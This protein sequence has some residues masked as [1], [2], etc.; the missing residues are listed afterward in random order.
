MTSVMEIQAE[1][2]KNLPQVCE[3][4]PTVETVTPKRKP[5]YLFLKRSFDILAALA[6]GVIWLLPMCV[7]AIL[8]K[9]DSKGPVILSRI[10]WEKAGRP[11]PCINSAPCG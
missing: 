11:S 1:E 10:A 7:I 8:I 2:E 6:A 3:L 5:V 9:L 4:E